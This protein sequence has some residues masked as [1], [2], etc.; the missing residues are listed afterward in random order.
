MVDSTQVCKIGFGKSRTKIYYKRQIH[1]L[2]I[3]GYNPYLVGGKRKK[4]SLW[5]FFSPA[6]VMEI[7]FKLL[8]K[9]GNNP[10]DGD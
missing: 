2:C 10:L 3:R 1:D 6:E 7:R 5:L 4:G 8:S 9:G